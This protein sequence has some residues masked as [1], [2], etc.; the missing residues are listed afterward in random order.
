MLTKIIIGGKYGILTV[1]TATTEKD[2]RGRTLYHCTCDCG[3]T[4][5][6]A[7]DRLLAGSTLSCGCMQRKHRSQLGGSKERLGWTAEQEAERIAK[8]MN[9]CSGI[10]QKGERYIAQ[11]KIQYKTHYIGI[12]DNR[13]EALVARQQVVQARI[14]DGDDAAV[15]F[16]ANIKKYRRN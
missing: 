14:K 3:G 2:Y 16:I 5:L 11:I 8:R 12:Y 9:G 7:A 15:E 6:V 4:R 1:D 10:Y 13:D